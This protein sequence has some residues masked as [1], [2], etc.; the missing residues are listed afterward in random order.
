MSVDITAPT[1]E[2]TNTN[3]LIDLPSG[4]GQWDVGVG[5]FNEWAFARDFTLVSSLV[6]TRQLKDKKAMR[7]PEKIDS[8]I[9]PDVDNE[10]TFNLGDIVSTQQGVKYSF[11]GGFEANAAYGFQYKEGDKYSG[12]AFASERYTWMEN[13]TE[14]NMQT[15]Q[16]G[17]G[18]STL[19]LYRAGK[20]KAPLGA[21]LNHTIVLDGKNVIK[22]PLTSFEFFI[23]F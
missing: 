16:L 10:V 14:Q 11:L 15:A 13:N 17:L 22:D 9:T 7:V 21:N 23:F 19:Q 20:F 2:K 8:T 3:N 5:A 4:D 6:Y 12:L 1:G 18:Y